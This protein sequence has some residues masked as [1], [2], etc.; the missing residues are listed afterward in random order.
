M[1]TSV[2]SHANGNGH[3]SFMVV[4]RTD[5]GFRVYDANHPEQQFIV[6]GDLSNPACSCD[7]FAEDAAN[8]GTCEHYRAVVEKYGEEDR[9]EREERAAIQSEGRTARKKRRAQANA[10]T[11]LMT[12]KRSVSPDGRI[13]SLSVEL[14]CPIDQL[15]TGDIKVRATNM[16]SLQREIA[17]SFLSGNGKGNGNGHGKSNG[18]PK[19]DSAIPAKMLS[20]SGTRNGNFSISFQANG[21]GA[22]FFGTR[23]E[24][25]GAIRA[26]GFDYSEEDVVEGI[27]LNLP[28]RVVTKTNGRYVNVD[29][30]LP[31]ASQQTVRT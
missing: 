6:H 22:K 16:L 4:S 12:L 18:H 1:S 2:Q 29:R 31:A 30:I 11:A 15:A 24:I 26:A 14:T 13:D 7:G 5:K 9:I 10:P 20:I 25:A 27:F 21:N 17:A 3:G 8:E 28:C 23:Q 19:P